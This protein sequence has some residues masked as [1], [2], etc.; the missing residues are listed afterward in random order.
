MITGISSKEIFKRLDDV[1]LQVAMAGKK[2]GKLRIKFLPSGSTL[3]DIRA[4]VKELSIKENF[5]ADFVCVD[6]LDLVNPGSC[7]VDQSD[8][9]TK[10]KLVSEE[11]RNFFIE[12]R[13]LGV[14]ASQLNRSTFD[15]VDFS[16]SG[17]A[18]GISKA[19]SAD[20]LAGIFTSRSM[21]ERGQIQLQL[22]KTRNSSGVGQKIDL[23]F[24]V[25]SLRITDSTSTGD[26]S[27]N[28]NNILN[29]IK[30]APKSNN[31]VESNGNKQSMLKDL[32]ENINNKK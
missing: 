11:L 3:N 19:N 12:L 2:S 18:G 6:Y 32:L 20:F 24:A 17:V 16:L 31:V 27:E 13:S 14:S 5:K 21:K 9:F 28:G 1:E 25:D 15:E 29:Q 10:D 30:N 7:K 22:L 26:Y 4:Y 23:D 8:F